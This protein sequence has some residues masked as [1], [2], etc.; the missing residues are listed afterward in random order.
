MTLCTMG[1][2]DVCTVVVMWTI[3]SDDVCAQWVVVMHVRWVV[4]MYDG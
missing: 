2:G 3:G 1:S 4:V